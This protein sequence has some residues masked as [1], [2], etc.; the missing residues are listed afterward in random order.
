MQNGNQRP[1]QL[2]QLIDKKITERNERTK[3]MLKKPDPIELPGNG[4][5]SVQVFLNY[6]A[7]SIAEQLTLL[8]YTLYKNIKVTE[9]LNNSWNSPKLRYRSPN[10]LALISRS[11]KVSYWIATSL[12]YVSLS[13]R[14]AVLEKI[15]DVCQC[16]V[17]LNNFNTLMGIIGSLGLSAIHRLKS[18]FNS[19]SPEKTK[20]LTRFQ[21]MMS[22]ASSYK[23]Y[24]AA[25]KAAQSP[26]LPYIGI[27]LTDLTFLETGNPDTLQEKINFRKRELIFKAI[28]EV[29][30]HQNNAYNIVPKEPLYSLLQE[31][32]Q[33]VNE[34][35]LYNLSLF[36][37]PRPT[38]SPH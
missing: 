1:K 17:E 35:E 9:L 18:T 14:V 36:F 8:D 34:D 2:R 11:T 6:D 23:N 4:L 10:L 15:I 22:T 24:R 20:N 29:V 16:L 38:T 32:P 27:S 31:L 21:E 28:E 5:S 26:I 7:K 19:I 3:L 33:N 30:L 13:K 12:L 37:E 25:L